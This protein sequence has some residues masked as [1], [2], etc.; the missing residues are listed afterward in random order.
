MP[1]VGYA[2]YKNHKYDN[3]GLSGLSI[4][5]MTSTL[6]FEVANNHANYANGFWA[7][8]GTTGAVPSENQ[9]AMGSGAG[10]VN[11]FV[12]GLPI[13]PIKVVS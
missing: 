1:P 11:N 2:E 4:I 13:R 12:I 6:C 10:Y 3:S 9:E 8:R 7:R 5:Y